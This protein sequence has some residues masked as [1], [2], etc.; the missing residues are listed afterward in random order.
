MTEF[1]GVCGVKGMSGMLIG[2]ECNSCG[3]WII[4]MEL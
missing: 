2:M 4:G 1:M 3:W